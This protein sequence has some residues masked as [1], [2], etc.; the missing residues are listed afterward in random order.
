MKIKDVLIIC[1]I[2]VM[3]MAVTLAVL[4][5]TRVDAI[6]QAP[7]VKPLIDQVRLV[8]GGC[9]FTLKTDKE[10]YKP[11][12]TSRVTLQ[13]VNPTKKPVREDVLVDLSSIR[14]PSLIS[15]SRIRPRPV[16]LWNKKCSINLKPGE[17]KTVSLDTGVK[18]PSGTMITITMTSIKPPVVA[19]RFT[20]EPQPAN[21][22][23]TILPKRTK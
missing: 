21:A 16:S 1:A 9:T 15:L 11:G 17:R 5:P 2:A 6:A 4:L 10:T 23:T 3:T 12:E 13:A 7:T 8:A 19:A 20:V 18:L 14:T 22:R